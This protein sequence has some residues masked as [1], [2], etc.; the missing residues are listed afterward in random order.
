MR[1]AEGPSETG[2]WTYG[3]HHAVSRLRAKRGAS[4]PHSPLDQGLRQRLVASRA[5]QAE[6][7]LR[8]RGAV[9]P[10]RTLI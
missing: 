10:E 5:R 6:A 4:F 3:D 2:G 9:A 7:E 1:N 8:R